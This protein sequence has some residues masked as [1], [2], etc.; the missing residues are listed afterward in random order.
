VDATSWGE[1]ATT[2]GVGM[3]G[4]RSGSRGMDAAC[5]SRRV[6]ALA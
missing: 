6:P 3:A 5:A 1:V 2:S 4:V